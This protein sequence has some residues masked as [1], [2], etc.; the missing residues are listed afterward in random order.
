M[1]G[2]T[3]HRRRTSSDALTVRDAVAP[4]FR[5]RRL[6]LAIFIGVFGG[7]AIAAVITPAKYE[8]EMKILVNRD[9]ADDVVTPNSDTRVISAQVPSVTEQDLNSEVELLKSR[10]L[11]ARVAA[12]CNL[13]TPAAGLWGR[14]VGTWMSP[15]NPD[16]ARAQRMARAVNALDRRI[17]AEPLKNTSIIHVTYTSPDPQLSARVL[18]T[19]AT[20]YQEKH[21]EVHRAA[22]AFRFFEREADYYSNQLAASEARLRHFDTAN[23]LVD[24]AAQEQLALQQAS[25]LQ[26][27]LDQDRAAIR[28][29]QQ[30]TDQLRVEQSASPQRQTTVIRKSPN[31]E[32]LAQLNNTLLSLELKRREMLTKYAPEYPLVQE[33][34]AQIADARKALARAQQA[35]VEQITT[36][37]TPAQDWIAT[38]MTKAET[39]RAGLEAEAGSV[40]REL[41]EARSAA[42][43]LNRDG[44]AQQDLAR[45]VKTAEGNY[46]LYVGKREEARISDLL[47]QK[48]IVNVS[49]AEAAAV[50]AFPMRNWP[51]I[52]ALGFFCAGG[53]GIGAAYAAD[54]LDPT[55]RSPDELS[56]YLDLKVLAAIPERTLRQ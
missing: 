53:A 33:T 37:R 21:A 13:D 28:A 39:D 31:A 49:I 12:T 3:I 30:R 46:L 23:G 38:E 22:G 36:D 5:H 48:R 14:T 9:R 56:R 20:L 45:E 16:I 2:L 8:A 40:Q 4:V 1:D 7:A 18:Q 10:D 41:L 29:T 17:I 55:F 11:L 6:A 47:D 15:R 19:L 43:R 42:M 26:A 54:R 25:Q 51:W 24:P 44:A 35:P 50:P 34:D 32:L 27:K 52:L